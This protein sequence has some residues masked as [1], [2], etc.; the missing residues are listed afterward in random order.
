MAWQLRDLGSSEVI[1]LP[2]TT[3][4]LSL[5]QGITS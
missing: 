4:R 3:A 5:Q 2:L 1:I